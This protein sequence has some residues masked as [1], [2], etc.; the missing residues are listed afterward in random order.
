MSIHVSVVLPA[1]KR[2]ELLARCLSA[3][4]AQDYDPAK[5]EIIVADESACEE[6]RQLVESLAA[7]KIAY[8]TMSQ[9]DNQRQERARQMHHSQEP[10]SVG[11]RDTPAVHYLSV[12]QKAGP[13]AARNHGW[14]AARGEII[15]FI[16]DDCIP[17]SGWLRCGC[18]AFEKGAEGVSGQVI[19]PVSNPPTDYELSRVELE[20]ED[21]A[22]ANCFYKRSLLEELGGFD[23]R[24]TIAC[25]EDSDLFFSLLEKG[26]RLATAPEAI[27][28]HPPGRV[29]WGASLR[30]QRKNMFKVLL[31]KK[32]PALYRKLQEIRLPGIYYLNVF[33]LLIA[34]GALLLQNQDFALV[35]GVLWLMLTLFLSLQRLEKTTHRASHVLEMILTS[36][37]IPPL[38]L[39]WRMLGMLKYRVLFL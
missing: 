36:A 32:H 35:S 1:N 4:I 37:L 17:S 7:H 24:F 30:Q 9:G 27:V 11:V 34:V 19:V 6:T 29:P 26:R 8:F 31:F 21:F 23:E 20:E 18:R 38:A 14:K 25:Q 16:H 12:P 2:P 10:L 15:A 28:F 5:Y 39:F 3:L 13:A 22:G 33:L